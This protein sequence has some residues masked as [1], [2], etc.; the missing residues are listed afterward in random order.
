MDA[1]D[2]SVKAAEYSGTSAKKFQQ[3]A[4]NALGHNMTVIAMSPIVRQIIT[5]V[6]IDAYEAAYKQALLDV[7]QVAR[8]QQ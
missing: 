4:M 3:Q 7:V 2:L 5:T 1:N 6:A 8:Q